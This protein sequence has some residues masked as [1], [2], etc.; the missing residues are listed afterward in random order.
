MNNTNNEFFID[1]TINA[2]TASS[3]AM[4]AIS[5]AQHQGNRNYRNDEMNNFSGISYFESY[6]VLFDGFDEYGFPL[7]SWFKNKFDHISQIQ[8]NLYDFHHNPNSITT[9]SLDNLAVIYYSLID[10]ENIIISYGDNENNTL[11]GDAN[12]DFL[13][14]FAGADSIQAGA[15]NDL[16]VID[17]DDNP[18]NI[19]AG[20]GDDIV[21][22]IDDGAVDFNLAD[23]H[24]EMMRGG[25][26][27]DRLVAGGQSSVVIAGGQGDDI[28]I[29]GSADDALAG[30]AGDD[31]VDGMQG[32][33][34]LYGHQGD[35]YLQG[36]AGDDYLDGGL[37]DDNLNG[38]LGNDI[39]FGGVGDDTLFGGNGYDMADYGGFSS[40]YQV[41]HSEV[42][43]T[44]YDT[45]TGACDELYGIERINF[46]DLSLDISRS[47]SIMVPIDDT[48]IMDNDAS[49]LIIQASQLLANDWNL[50]S[51]VYVIAA[52]TNVKGGEAT[53]LDSGDIKFVLDPNYIGLPSFDYSLAN[54]VSQQIVSFVYADN[55]IPE[56]HAQVNML[57]TVAPSDD[58]YTAQ[59][60]LSAIHV[61]DVW[62][63]Y[64]GAGVQVTIAN[65]NGPFD[66]HH[67]E[68]N[69]NVSADEYDA[70]QNC[71]AEEDISG[72][73]TAVAGV[74]AAERNGFGI[75][76]V[77][78]AANLAYHGIANQVEPD[79]YI[80][81]RRVVSYEMG[82]LSNDTIVSNSWHFIGGG[83][84]VN[85]TQS[86]NIV[87]GLL[88][89]EVEA[90]L[91]DAA[92]NGR[93][94][95]G[96]IMLQSA[97]N[98][99]M[100]GDD[101]NLSNLINSRFNITVA[102]INYPSDIARGEFVNFP[103]FSTPGSA[104]LVAAPGSNIITTRLSEENEEE[105]TV[106]C[107][108][109][110]YGM[111][112]SG[113][114]TA[115]AGTSFSTP[116]VAA[117]TALML[118]ANP[119]LGA[120]DVQKILAFSARLVVDDNVNW[121]NNAATESNLNGLH[122][123]REYGFGCVDA[124]A[125]V[126]LAESWQQQPQ[127]YA[128]EISVSGI[129]HNPTPIKDNDSVISMINISS[130]VNVEYA[131]ILVDIDHSRLNDLSI[132]LISPDGTRSTLLQ[133]TDREGDYVLDDLQHLHFNLTSANFYG[134]HSMGDWQLSITDNVSGETGMLND[135]QLSLYGSKNNDD[136]V[137]IFTDE[138]NHTQVAVCINDFIGEDTINASALLSNSFID[139]HAG[140]ISQ[141]NDCDLKITSDS[142][143]EN[144]YGGDGDDIL[145]G[146]GVDNL[147]SSGRGNNHLTGNG[148]ADLFQIKQHHGDHDVITDFEYNN[149]AEKIDLHDFD[150]HDF[151]ELDIHMQGDDTYID[152]INEQQLILE[153][154]HMSDLVVDDFIL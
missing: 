97:G 19:D 113:D 9:A 127:T 68:L 115:M 58:L 108:D 139:L 20:A 94:G 34:T 85:F 37:G 67:V 83:F 111:W 99:I 121:Y 126:R 43:F 86:D 38:G 76:G 41:F 74:V 150:L 138:F 82:D 110:M 52:I 7:I 16:I 80:N 12:A 136:N 98:A 77:A 57:S 25:N 50:T 120:R 6:R 10:A 144:V 54:S 60:Y 44:V 70:I 101:T 122:F 153:N 45:R 105:S 119:T 32:N 88:L 116:I 72:H 21:W 31:K 133:H 79:T 4:P 17:A 69:D 147:L 131:E 152:F 65:L 104:I 5:L 117:V 75:V 36:N 64:T 49:S 23:L 42:G 14:G 81:D 125:A 66:Y 135:W 107:Y 47:E 3:G 90:S 118:E 134:E 124:H 62:E 89:S 48:I 40:Y 71:F 30:Q 2:D 26:G 46:F 112:A 78:Y 84:S 92:L 95:L 39:L 132:V 53:L 29:G 55:Q 11:N 148:G 102:A 137:Y 109:D 106:N 1:L 8:N 73:A 59:W 151:S 27:N 114:Y 93:A 28:I 87:G 96:A 143:I 24:A 15:G 141:V 154:V 129:Y 123:S 35:D 130:D 51:D 63:D 149:V 142:V 145:I 61:Q 100:Q 22:V 128:N 140:A 13:V 56:L 33:D 146:N 103:Y 91:R 18:A